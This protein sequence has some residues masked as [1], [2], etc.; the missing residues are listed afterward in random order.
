MSGCVLRVSIPTEGQL[1]AVLGWLPFETLA[2]FRKDTLP[3]PTAK[4]FSA[5]NGF[6]V[7]VSDNEQGHVGG[8]IAD[9]ELFLQRHRKPLERL[10]LESGVS[11]CLDFGTYISDNVA[12]CSHEFPP[13]LLRLCGALGLSVQ[14]S[15]YRTDESA[16]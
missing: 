15:V 13:A 10:S 16:D 1:D 5:Y 6:N 4:R 7:L 2:V 9:A 14:V 8:Q 12:A 11:V 3:R